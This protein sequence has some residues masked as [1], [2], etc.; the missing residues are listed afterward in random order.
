[1]VG[2][3]T[4]ILQAVIDRGRNVQTV[5][6]RIFGCDEDLVA[7][8]ATLADGNPSFSLIS[9][10]LG[11]ICIMKNWLVTWETRDLG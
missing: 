7:R 4:H 9:V 6:T 5:Q 10:R 11:C 8:E 3:I 1:M 2:Q